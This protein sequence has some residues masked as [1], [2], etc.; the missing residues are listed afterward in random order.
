MKSATT[1][2]SDTSRSD[3]SRRFLFRRP[4]H[5]LGILFGL[6]ARLVVGIVSVLFAS[7]AAMVMGAFSNWDLGVHTVLIL[8]VLILVMVLFGEHLRYQAYERIRAKDTDT[9][10]VELKASGVHIDGVALFHRK[11]APQSIRFALFLKRCIDLLLASWTLIVLLPIFVVIATMIKISDPGPIL[12][13]QTRYGI[14]GR[15]FEVFK[16]RTMYV[17]HHTFGVTRQ[18]VFDR[19]ITPVGQFLRRTS[20]DELPVF[21]AVLR[22][23]MSLVGTTAYRIE[24][25]VLK[26]LA[27]AATARPGI[28][29]LA[30]I[31]G[32]SP[33][34]ENGVRA[35]LKLDAEYVTSW[36]LWLDMRIALQSLRRHTFGT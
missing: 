9:F 5:D 18:D 14:D 22:G 12:F 21:L 31:S 3:R 25:P 8:G 29:T 30:A 23:H 13:R 17:D 19:R 11:A 15:K 16:F 34:N 4:P 26:D 10:E 20:L 35:A 2:V 32:V 7:A 1:H 27:D 33:I 24:P 28:A 6:G 36:S